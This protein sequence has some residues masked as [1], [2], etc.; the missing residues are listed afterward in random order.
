[1]YSDVLNKSSAVLNVPGRKKCLKALTFVPNNGAAL[2]DLSTW[3]EK[4]FL[5]NSAS[6]L[7]GNRPVWPLIGC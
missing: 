3:I 2:Q 5:N 7:I 6:L 4:V 1:M